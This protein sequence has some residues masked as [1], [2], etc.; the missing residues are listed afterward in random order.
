MGGTISRMS[1]MCLWLHMQSPINMEVIILMYTYYRLH[2][3]TCDIYFCNIT[4]CLLVITN[5]NPYM[6]LTVPTINHSK[7]S[8][9]FTYHQVQHSKLLHGV[10][11][12]LS[13]LYG[14]QNKQR[15]SLYS[16]L[17]Y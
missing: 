4:A 12:A 5:N 13:V 2:R 6:I 9:F 10:S 15:L 8:G 7:P 14:S 3:E 17:T 16:A 1:S 11:F